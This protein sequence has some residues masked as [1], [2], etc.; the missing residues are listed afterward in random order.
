MKTMSQD[1]RLMALTS[2]NMMGGVK[3]L[4]SIAKRDPKAYLA[5]VARCL[6]KDDGVDLGAVQFVVQQIH[7]Q[8]GPVAGVLNSPVAEHVGPPLR[9][10]AA[11]GEVV[12]VEARHG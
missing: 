3:Y 1:L 5:F 8:A 10:A 2:L 7:V 11:G 4:N 12:D 6:I 9:L